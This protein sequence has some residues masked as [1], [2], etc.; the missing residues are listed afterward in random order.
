MKKGEVPQEG[1]YLEKAKM[2]EV[3][4]V[5]D[6]NDRY[7]TEKSSGWDAKNSALDE[8]MALIEERVQAAK[9]Q[10]KNGTASP[11][12]YFM[13]L[14]KMDWN[15]LAAYVGKW[16]W[17]VKGDAK[18]KNFARLSEKNLQ[19]YADAFGISADELKNFDGN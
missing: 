5:T 8:S 9:T 11:I 14:N 12:H 15:V 17:F 10:V 6:E 19:K 4:Y 3:L 1:G 16:V 13:E 7:T 2:T 18:P